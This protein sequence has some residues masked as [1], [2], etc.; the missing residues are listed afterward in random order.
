MLCN[1]QLIVLYAGIPITT[2]GYVYV[3]DIL[4]HPRFRGLTE[5]TVRTIVADCRKQRFALLNRDGRLVIKANQGHS[6]QV[7]T[8]THTHMHI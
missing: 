2:D 4:S 6:L 8:H 3:D 7:L 1:Q 5:A